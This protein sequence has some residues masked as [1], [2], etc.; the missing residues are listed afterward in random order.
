MYSVELSDF[1]KSS[2][3]LAPTPAPKCHV[4]TL[5]LRASDHVPALASEVKVGTRGLGPL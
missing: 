2:V 1:F 5:P 4:P 3:A